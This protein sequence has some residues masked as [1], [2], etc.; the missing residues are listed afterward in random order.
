[1]P[2]MHMPDPTRTPTPHYT[3]T[4]ACRRYACPPCTCQTPPAPR[5]HTTLSH[6]PAGGT[7]APHA[8]A[9][10]RPHPDATLHSH[11]S[12]QLVRVPH[13]HMPDP[14]R[15][16]TPHYTLTQARRHPH[17]WTTLPRTA[18]T[19]ATRVLALCMRR[20]RTAR[21]L[22]HLPLPAPP[23]PRAHRAACMQ[24]L[25]GVLPSSPLA[26]SALASLAIA[27][28]AAR[29]VALVHFS[30]SAGAQI[31]LGVLVPHLAPER[32]GSAEGEGDAAEEG[33]GD[34][35]GRRWPD[36][37]LLAKVPW[38]GDYQPLQLP[39]LEAAAV[40]C[41]PTHACHACS[42]LQLPEPEAAAVRRPPTPACHAC[43]RRRGGSTPEMRSARKRAGRRSQQQRWGP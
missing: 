14:A 32:G 36:H 3:L 5:R 4:Q 20:M 40:R 6:K 29:K 15:T 41:S 26:A 43:T 9:R 12:L 25:W 18:A 27:M 23:A 17:L 24:T 22:L 2:P 11:A 37:L 13:M 34:A 33:A 19:A 21:A 7:H 28:H 38:G 35:G 31:S 16:P 42:P 8:H 10:P 1:M 39:E 30:L